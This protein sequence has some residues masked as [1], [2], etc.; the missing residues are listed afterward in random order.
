MDNRIALGYCQPKAFYIFGKPVAQSP[1]P[2]IHTAGFYS[3]ASPH[4]YG[5]FETNDAEVAFRA[6]MQTGCG[7]GSVTIPLK[8]SL[9]PYM[10]SLSQSAREIGAINTVTKTSDGNL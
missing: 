9:L 1:S 5:R 10:A 3:T 6:L 2:T 7:G 8:E 4:S